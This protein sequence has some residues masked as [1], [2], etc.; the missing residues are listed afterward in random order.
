MRITENQND[1]QI[2]WLRT[3]FLIRETPSRYEGRHN[4]RTL[5]CSKQVDLT[6]YT[7]GQLGNNG[8]DSFASY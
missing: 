3:I 5:S 7:I 6:S 1:T 4:V 8:I 2:I